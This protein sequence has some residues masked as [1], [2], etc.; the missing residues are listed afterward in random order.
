MAGLLVVVIGLAGLSFYRAGVAAQRQAERLAALE[1]TLAEAERQRDAAAA[2]LDDLALGAERDTAR[3]G[4]LE[5]EIGVYVEKLMGLPAD[6]R[7]VLTLDDV[8]GLRR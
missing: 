7:C 1:S 3:I 2:A 4:A 5:T 8:D 6:Q